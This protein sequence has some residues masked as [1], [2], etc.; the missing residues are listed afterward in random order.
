MSP[1][2][3]L[4][5]ILL[6]SNVFLSDKFVKSQEA[7]ANPQKDIK[8]FDNIFFGAL[9]VFIIASA[10]Q[11]SPTMYAMMDADFF[12]ACIFFIICVIILNFWLINLFVAVITNS[13]ASIRAETKESA[14]GAGK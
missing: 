5:G 2:P 12:V 3:D 8:S 1:W 11:W 7:N 10:N 9:Q 14:F 6:P 13:F 4:Q